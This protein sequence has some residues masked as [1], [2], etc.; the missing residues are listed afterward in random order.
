MAAGSRLDQ[1]ELN[2]SNAVLPKFYVKGSRSIESRS[3]GIARRPV[4]NAGPGT[5]EI[6][7][8]KSLKLKPQALKKPQLKNRISF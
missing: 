6:E 5:T 2:T 1:K 3:H 8:E 7:E 4:S